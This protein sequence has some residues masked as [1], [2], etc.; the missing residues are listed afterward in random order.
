MPT[1]TDEKTKVSVKDKFGD[2]DVGEREGAYWAKWPDGDIKK[3]VKALRGIRKDKR[4]DRENDLLVGDDMM[5]GKISALHQSR[6][7]IMEKEH[8]SHKLPKELRAKLSAEKVQVIVNR[9][10]KNIAVDMPG[11]SGCNLLLMPGTGTGKGKLEEPGFHVVNAYQEAFLDRDALH[12]AG[13]EVE[14]YDPAIHGARAKEST[15]AYVGKNPKKNRRDKL[16]TV[17]SLDTA[18]DPRLVKMGDMDDKMLQ[19]AAVRTALN[20]ALREN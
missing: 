16:A 13:L 8:L 3:L 4:S 1:A 9:S 2:L 5:H 10:S 17:S 12:A 19:D 6:Q 18:D 14:D 15:R 11:G 7:R 20:N